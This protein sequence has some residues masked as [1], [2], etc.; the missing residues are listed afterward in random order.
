MSAGA[1]A[2]LVDLN[3]GFDWLMSWPAV[4]GL[5]VAASLEVGAYFIPWVDHAL[6]TIATPAAVIAG[7]LS[8]ATQIESV[9]PLMTWASALIAGG[10]VAGVVQAASVGTRVASSA[11]TGGLANPFVSAVESAV[12]AVLSVLAIVVPVVAIAAVVLAGLLV[13]RW[14]WVRRSRPALTV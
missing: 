1:K 12:A 7:T 6:D 14:F 2:G 8:A 5:G 9:G 10:G 11:T 4:L 3:D 13:G